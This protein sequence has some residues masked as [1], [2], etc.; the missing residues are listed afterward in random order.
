MKNVERMLRK[1]E[2]AE[3]NGMKLLDVAPQLYV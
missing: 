3:H 2:F 1:D